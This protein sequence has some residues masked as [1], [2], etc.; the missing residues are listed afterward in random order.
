VVILASP[1]TL[2]QLAKAR[3]VVTIIEVRSQRRYY[4][5]STG[6]GAKPVSRPSQLGA[7]SEAPFRPH[8]EHLAQRRST[9]LEASPPQRIIE[10]ARAFGAL[11][12]QRAFLQ[13][14]QSQGATL[15]VSCSVGRNG[16]T[17][18]LR[19]MVHATTS[20]LMSKRVPT[21]VRTPRPG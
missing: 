17:M 2:A 14:T 4:I 11:C 8:L 16:A 12:R 1:N 6:N 19:P 3:L 18:G 13:F 7:V 20:G 15:R 21:R 5:R 9:S 10:G